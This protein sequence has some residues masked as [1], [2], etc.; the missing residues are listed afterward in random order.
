MAGRITL[1]KSVLLAI[2]NYFM[3][4]V[5]LPISICREIEKITRNF[6]WGSSTSDH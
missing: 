4:T 2:P 3:G 5:H 1:A 6:I